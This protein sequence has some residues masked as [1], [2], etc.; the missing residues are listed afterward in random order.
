MVRAASKQPRVGK[1]GTRAQPKAQ[2]QRKKKAATKG[3]QKKGNGGSLQ[4]MAAQVFDANHPMHMALP[5]HV[6]PYVVQRFIVNLQVSPST[7]PDNFSYVVCMPNGF[8]PGHTNQLNVAN[9]TVMISGNSGT[10]LSAAARTNSSD[11][12]SL[13]GTGA[14]VAF[15][16]MSA[17]IL[18][19]SS[20]NVSAGRVWMGRLSAPIE[21]WGNNSST[22]DTAFLPFIS[23]HDVRPLSYHAL[24]APKKLIAAPLDF[25]Q[26]ETFLG[27]QA[28]T[29]SQHNTSWNALTPLVFVFSH[30]PTGSL[31]S[32]NIRL[33]L[34]ARVRYPVNDSRYSMH[35]KHKPTSQ[36][37][38]NK[39]V[40]GAESYVGGVIEET[41]H[42]VIHNL[43]RIGNRAAHRAVAGMLG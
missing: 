24:Y 31:T 33:S 37:T 26:Y 3:R 25:I 6:M 4:A 28:A 40:S 34:E 29:L 11:L 2:P 23:R 27:V 42:G 16:A 20:Q 32:Y 38:F 14:E 35:Q 8:A 15:S 21:N 10:L 13:A 7:T 22:F 43:E 5:M 9:S 39:L 12:N 19:D 30:M 41:T 36:D 17:S 18:C 1:N